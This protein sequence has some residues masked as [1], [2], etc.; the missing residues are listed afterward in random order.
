MVEGKEYS[1]YIAAAGLDCRMGCT[2]SGLIN[3]DVERRS[4]SNI[5]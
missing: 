5:N 2:A 4:Q 1:A 3:E